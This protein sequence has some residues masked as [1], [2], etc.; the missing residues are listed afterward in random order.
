[1]KKTYKGNQTLAVRPRRSLY[2]LKLYGGRIQ[3]T[4]IQFVKYCMYGTD[5]SWRN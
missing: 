1:M 4:H 5:H 2:V 3:G